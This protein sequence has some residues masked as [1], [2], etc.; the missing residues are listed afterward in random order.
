[1]GKDIEERAGNCS[2]AARGVAKEGLE[3]ALSG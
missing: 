3:N 2:P 1:M